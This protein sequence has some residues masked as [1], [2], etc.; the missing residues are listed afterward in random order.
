MAAVTF[1]DTY[2]IMTSFVTSHHRIYI[3]RQANLIVS[4]T[5]EISLLNFEEL[6]NGGFSFCHTT[7]SGATMNTGT[8]I[9][10]C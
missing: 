6:I 10:L 8:S 2:V 4:V 5:D 7:I 3:T 1:K 9:I